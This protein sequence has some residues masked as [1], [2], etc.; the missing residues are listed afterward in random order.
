MDKSTFI[1]RADSHL[2]V[3]KEVEENEEYANKEE[4]ETEDAEEVPKEEISS[5][6]IIW[7]IDSNNQISVKKI[8]LPFTPQSISVSPHGHKLAITRL[9]TETSCFTDIWNITNSPHFLSTIIHT[10][11]DK[12]KWGNQVNLHYYRPILWSNSGEFD[13]TLFYIFYSQHGDDYAPEK[14]YVWNAYTG[15][16]VGQ[17]NRFDTSSKLAF[18][19]FIVTVRN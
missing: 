18:N 6:Y 8:C 16:K 13:S 12:H 1:F 19:Y 4:D 17:W 10:A 15:Q 2:I 14:F 5:H 3:G 11:S 9:T 7:Q